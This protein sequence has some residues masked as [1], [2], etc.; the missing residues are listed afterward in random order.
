MSAGLSLWRAFGHGATPVVRGLL[1][2]RLARGKEDG[3]RLGE[4]L[5]RAGMRRPDGPLVWLHG[6]SVGEA[7]SILPVVDRLLAARDDLHVLVT[8]GTVT[9]AKLMAERLP[10]RAL[11][12]Y[13]P[14]D[15]PAAV[16]A[17][18]VH[19]RPDLA[20]WVESE[21]WP[22]LI[23]A[24]H[25]ART[26]FLLINGRMSERS[27]G[28]WRW[29]SFLI[30]PLLARFALVLAQTPA[31]ALRFRTLGAPKVEVGGNLKYAAP[32]LDCDADELA[33][34][35]ATLGTRPLWLAASTHPGEE[36]SVAAAHAELARRFPGLLT[37]IAPRHPDR[38]VELAARLAA[39][40]RAAGDAVPQ[41]GLYVADTLGELGLWYRLA[42]IA[43][44]GG[45]LV[46]KGGQNLL[47]PARLDCAVL[48]GPHIGNFTEVAAALAQAGAAQT[49]TADTLASTVAALL[50]DP[51]RRQAMA[52]AAR[53][54]TARDD[55]VLDRVLAAALATLA[56]R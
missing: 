53:I 47:E 4:R 46:P 42:P 39:P 5:G 6:A 7:M 48:H 23:S 2:R 25:D 9:S 19:W 17:F 20:L 44:V 56:K 30:R 21:L 50:A 14:V 41:G 49:V 43:L 24:A 18:V 45:S 26:P 31:D 13:V 12:Q 32:P 3:A 11:H 22:G 10:P 27:H 8:T 35:R 16:D 40:R 55:G 52:D 15:L 1:Q 51:A 28:R 38:G 36:D 34:L 29:A 37:I 33:R 54:A